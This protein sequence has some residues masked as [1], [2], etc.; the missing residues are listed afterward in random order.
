M[1]PPFSNLLVAIAWMACG[2]LHAAAPP[3]PPYLLMQKALDD[4]SIKAVFFSRG[5]Y[6]CLKTHLR[7]NWSGFHKHPKWLV[8][9]TGNTVFH[10]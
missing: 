9:F 10:S 1:K 6:G 8:G 3:P 5:G 2:V 7:L 4:K